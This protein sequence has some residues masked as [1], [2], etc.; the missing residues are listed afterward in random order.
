MRFFHKSCFDGFSG[1]ALLQILL[2][3]V[4]VHLLAGGFPLA[5]HHHVICLALL[6]L[7]RLCASFI[8]KEGQQ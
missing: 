4:H 7:L 5:L 6:A 3:L 2:Q 1:N 8:A